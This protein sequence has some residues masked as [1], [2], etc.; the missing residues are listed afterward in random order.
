MA[1]SFLGSLIGLGLAFAVS[2][3]PGVGPLA[4]S[5]AFAAGNVIGGAIFGPEDTSNVIGPR[6]QDLSIASST[7]GKGWPIIYGSIRVPGNMLW[8]KS[9]IEVQHEEEIGRGPRRYVVAGPRKAITRT[10]FEYFG[11][12]AMGFSEGP[13]K[14]IR[15]VWADSKLIVDVNP[16]VVGSGTFKYGKHLYREYLGT[17]L[18]LPDPTIEADKGVGN[19][20]GHRGICYMVFNNLPLKDF[21]N[22]LPNITAEIVSISLDNFTKETFSPPNNHNP[23]NSF[24]SLFEPA[25]FNYLLTGETTKTNRLTGDLIWEFNILDDPGMVAIGATI[26]AGLVSCSPVTGDFYMGWDGSGAGIAVFNKDGKFIDAKQHGGSAASHRMQEFVLDGARITFYTLGGTRLLTSRSWVVDA[27]LAADTGELDYTWLNTF[28]QRAAGLNY[29]QFAWDDRDGFTVPGNR[30]WAAANTGAG[31]CS[32]LR[33]GNDGG[34]SGT[35][36]DLTTGSPGLPA[37]LNFQGICYDRRNDVLLVCFDNNIVKLDPETLFAIGAIGTH[38]DFDVV[39][40]GGAVGHT[41]ASFTDNFWNNQNTTDG[42]VAMIVNPGDFV[43]VDVTTMKVTL[44]VD[45]SVE[46]PGDDFENGPIHDPLTG[47]LWNTFTNAYRRYIFGSNSEDANVEDIV[48]DICI[49]AGIA[50]GDVDTTALTGSVKGYL[51]SDPT[52]ARKSIEPLQRLFFFDGAETD[53]KLKFILRTGAST[54]TIPSTDL[55]ARDEGEEDVVR[56]AE[57]R[58]QEVEIP[59][60]VTLE[61]MNKDNDYNTGTQQAQRILET[62]ITTVAGRGVTHSRHT[63][64]VRVPVAITDAFA[65]DVVERI[66]LM[67]FVERTSVQFTLPPKH[68]DLDPTDI[69]TITK[70]SDDL[71]AD[72]IIRLTSIE[73]GDHFKIQCSGLLVETA[74]FSPTT[75]AQTP[76]SLIAAPIGVSV[77]TKEFLL[78]LP[79]I[80]GSLDDGGHAWFGGS[81]SFFTPVPDWQGAFLSCGDTSAGPFNIVTMTNKKTSWGHTQTILPVDECWTAPDREQTLD[82]SW[83]TGDLPTS[84]TDD[85]DWYANNK[86]LAFI[87]GELVKFKTVTVLTGRKIRLT[88]FLRGRLGTEN[89]IAAHGIISEFILLENLDNQVRFSD[90]SVRNIKRFYASESIASETDTTP[91]VG[92]T[93]TSEASLPNTVQH[94]VVDK[95][96]SG[97]L[98][99]DWIRRTRYN[100][101]LWV[102]D[103]VPLNETSENYEV[104]IIEDSDFPSVVLLL[105]LD[106]TDGD[107]TTTD[108][109]PTTPHVITFVENAVIDTA[110]SKFGVSS[111]FFD[112]TAD[113]IEAPQTTD[114]QFF[115]NA[116][117]MEG[118]FNW[119]SDTGISHLL[120]QWSFSSP[121]NKSFAIYYFSAGNSLELLLSVNGTTTLTDIAASFTPTLDVWYHIAVSYE[122]ATTTYRLFVDGVSL[123]SSTTERNLF[124]S[125]QPFTVGS[126]E[127]GLSGF[128]G[129][130]D[131][132]RVTKGVTR[133]VNNFTPPTKAFAT[134]AGVSVR[135]IKVTSEQATYTEADQ[136]TDFGVSV[137]RSDLRAD[138]YQL[139]DEVGRGKKQSIGD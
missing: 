49:R 99:I 32:I 62:D 111:V 97:D 9:I 78:N 43:L 81:P 115:T 21:G 37:G 88:G 75:V 117:T 120:G 112:G 57:P 95:L 121:N 55:A 40:D 100:F 4:I 124:A 119:T 108:L 16:S 36:V 103:A 132:I 87:N 83:I 106:G 79:N 20:P 22:H 41:T 18:Q 122:V 104:D 54:R 56:L 15:R 11:Q 47:W 34:V 98:V 7:Y 138:I 39:S 30:A 77:T 2:F 27:G 19:V 105:P 70:I 109:S 60:T 128:H 17:E 90:F 125:I 123:G 139:S 66:L 65:R 38:N 69:I 118:H 52:S 126:E 59:A 135:T 29:F 107:I 53:H 51:L 67:G 102:T 71:T 44:R 45:A 136:Q 6:L 25:M 91:V 127:N 12:F 24:A 35:A 131:N 58:R 3:I 48:N 74:V 33:L 68:I 134:S 113:N 82:V 89:S 85:L 130:A 10:V 133:Y 96:T 137:A 5:L 84:A 86:N 94:V 50:S 63:V 72:L 76:G 93:N 64:D 13:V 8:G 42:E 14:S 129:H 23:D 31:N 110:K 114:W 73:L 61:Y 116:W 28:K 1:S 92:F 46:F 26:F 101:G 80:K